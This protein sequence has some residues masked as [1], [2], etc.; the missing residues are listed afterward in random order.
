M[1]W[2]RIQ[3]A[4]AQNSTASASVAVSLSGV[5]AGH[6]V[7]CC[8]NRLGT[9]TQSSF[10]DSQS[11]TWTLLVDE[12]QSTQNSLSVYYSVITTG[13][14]LTITSTASASPA[15]QSITADEYSF[16]AGTIS[17]S[18]AVNT[19]YTQTAF[20]TG[21]ATFSSNVLVIGAVG[22]LFNSASNFS[23][24]AGFTQ[25]ESQPYS[26][27]VALGL[28]MADVQNT[29]TSPQTPA[30]TFTGGTATYAGVTGV[31]QSSGDISL[32]AGSAST[33]SVGNEVASVSV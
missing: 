8:V 24:N 26:N 17:A 7:I 25:R 16:T 10:S 3:G 27:G 2:A 22:Y 28:T 13:G 23:W 31:F 11:N 19:G 32:T 33:T 29:T 1:T 15:Y 20:S 14:S 4:G 18:H 9:T 5:V 12:A 30:G 6:L 21:S